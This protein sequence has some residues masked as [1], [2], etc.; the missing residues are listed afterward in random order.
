MFSAPSRLLV[1]FLNPHPIPL[2]LTQTHLSLRRQGGNPP[3]GIH[4][5][6]HPHRVRRPSG[7]RALRLTLFPRGCRHLLPL[8]AFLPLVFLF[9]DFVFEGWDRCHTAYYWGNWRFWVDWEGWFGMKWL[10]NCIWGIVISHMAEEFPDPV[11]LR[12]DILF[13]KSYL[14]M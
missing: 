9:L 13:I 5:S 11:L 6:L 1:L 2:S 7:G 14:N 8:L 4:L 3:R 12:L 10:L